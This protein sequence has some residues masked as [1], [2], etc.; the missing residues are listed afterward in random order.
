MVTCSSN[1]HK[2]FVKTLAQREK[3]GLSR[4]KSK[5][6]DKFK[7]EWKLTFLDHFMILI[8]RWA[9]VT[10]SPINILPWPL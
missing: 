7:F 4:A 1:V 2:P 5:V 9:G 10:V 6:G 8:L 3:I